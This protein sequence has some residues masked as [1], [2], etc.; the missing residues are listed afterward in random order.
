MVEPNQTIVMKT[1]KFSKLFFSHKEKAT[2]S[3]TERLSLLRKIYDEQNS[4]VRKTLFYLVEE[5][6][7]DDLMQEVFTKVW[8]NLDSFQERSSSKTW[9]YRIV[10]NTAYDHLRKR[11]RSFWQSDSSEE[12]L[13][14]IES[15]AASSFERTECISRHLK[16]ATKHMLKNYRFLV[17]FFEEINVSGKLPSRKYC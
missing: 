1:A 8:R 13:E 3:E 10:V 2:L 9:I 5:S 12:A 4:Y 7:V 15:Y 6:A 16:P 17:F 11:R 14:N